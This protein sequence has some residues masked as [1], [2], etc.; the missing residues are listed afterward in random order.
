MRE[1]RDTMREPSG[2]A[3]RPNAIHIILNLLQGAL[4]AVVALEQHLH[5]FAQFENLPDIVA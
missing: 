4:V 1:I 2:M 5:L 3:I